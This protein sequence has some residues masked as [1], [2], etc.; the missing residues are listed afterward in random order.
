MLVDDPVVVSL[1]AGE[2]VLDRCTL[3]WRN[4]VERSV[5]VTA[6]AVLALDLGADSV[7]ARGAGSGAA[8]V[9]GHGLR[10]PAAL[11]RLLAPL[12]ELLPPNAG[13]R[14]LAAEVAAARRNLGGGVVP[15]PGS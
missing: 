15:Q 8:V 4:E 3:R 13:F 6:V 9:T 10:G 1:L 14:P 5:L 2:E 7:L 11:T 12:R